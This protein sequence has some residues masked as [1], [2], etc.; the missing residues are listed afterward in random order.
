MATT[1]YEPYKCTIIY[2]KNVSNIYVMLYAGM[3]MVRRWICT[4]IY[5][6]RKITTKTYGYHYRWYRFCIPTYG[7]YNMLYF[8]TMV[9][10]IWNNF[11]KSQAKRPRQADDG[12]GVLRFGIHEGEGGSNEQNHEMDPFH[13]VAANP[14]GSSRMVDW[15][16]HMTGVFLDGKC[17]HIWHTYGSVMG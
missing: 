8:I 9:I 16:G 12:R 1:S 13:T 17:Y 7:V 3:G 2:P 15:C 10:A 4:S 6:F 5:T 11:N 14:I